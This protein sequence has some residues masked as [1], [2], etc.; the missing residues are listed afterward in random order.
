MTMTRFYMVDPDNEE[1]LLKIPV[2]VVAEIE[3]AALDAAVQR[4]EGVQERFC[5]NNREYP[6]IINAIKGDQP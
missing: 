5:F 1:R 4:V 6:A 2:R 3:K